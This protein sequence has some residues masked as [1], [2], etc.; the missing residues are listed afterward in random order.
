MH[1]RLAITLSAPSRTSSS[2][3]A[4]FARSWPRSSSCTERRVRKRRAREV[5]RV[6]IGDAFHV[7]AA[8]TPELRAEGAASIRTSTTEKPPFRGE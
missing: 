4:A 8:A 5:Y 1:T 2:M 7:D 6:V 3:R